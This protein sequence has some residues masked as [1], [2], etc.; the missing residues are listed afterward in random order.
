MGRPAQ[1]EA[2][3]AEMR[4]RI[5]QEAFEL[6]KQG[7]F[8]AVSIRA[9]AARIG[10]VPSGIYHYYKNRNELV[11]AIWYEPA[12][13]ATV[14]ML[15]MAA[16]TTDPITRIE[17]ALRIYIQL[18]FEHPEIYREAFMFVRPKSE[19]PPPRQPMDRL[20]FHNVLKT[21]IEQAQAD[22]RIRT[23]DASLMAQILWAGL[24]GALAL[25]TNIDRW[26][27]APSDQLVE[28]MLNTLMSGLR[29]G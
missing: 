17:K 3:R 1:S 5:R 13:D 26:A 8:D 6:F 24:H 4:E 15:S 18:A 20:D 7:G 21:S 23:G 16:R 11:Q 22:G 2:Q 28:E 19:H 25:P 29:T 12:R 9:V 10:I 27:Y 14:R